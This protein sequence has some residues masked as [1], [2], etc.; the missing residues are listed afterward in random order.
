M[1][2]ASGYKAFCE[3]AL[4]NYPDR[5]KPGK[6]F[7]WAIALSDVMNAECSDRFAKPS[8]RGWNSSFNAKMF[9]NQYTKIGALAQTYKGLINLKTPF[10]LYLYTR[11]IWELQPKT[12]LELGSLQGGSG[13]WFADQMSALCENQGEVHSFDIN[14]ECIHENARSP[15]VTF[16]QID[17]SNTANFDEDLLARLPH[18]WIVVDDAHVQVFSIFSYLER[19]LVSGD[20][21]IIEDNPLSADK[22]II[23]GLQFIEK[24]GFLIDT[25]YTDAFGTNFTCAPNAWLRKS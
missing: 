4:K 14:T 9:P 12:I 19:F 24:M 1:K 15:M 11:L 20:Y 8:A 3:A 5:T 21:Y 16:H 18:P 25:Y 13:L 17:L 2:L 22:E 7:D 6:Y 23:E 10:D